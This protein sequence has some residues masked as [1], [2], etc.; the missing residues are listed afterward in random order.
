MIIIKLSNVLFLITCNQEWNFVVECCV[1]INLCNIFN[2]YE[3]IIIEI[4]R[5]QL[6]LFHANILPIIEYESDWWPHYSHFKLISSSC[7]RTAR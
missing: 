7:D 5:V 1:N 4:Q 3:I 6:L 2:I